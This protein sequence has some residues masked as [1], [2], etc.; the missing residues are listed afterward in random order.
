[1][2][3]T[4]PCGYVRNSPV[5]LADPLGIEPGTM[6]QRGYLSN[7]RKSYPGLLGEDSNGVM[8]LMKATTTFTVTT[9]GILARRVQVAALLKTYPKD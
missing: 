6:A 7:N 5:N 8:L 4:N 3:G 9:R 2:G 1:M